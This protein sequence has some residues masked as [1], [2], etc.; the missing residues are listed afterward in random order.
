MTFTER[1]LWALA[2]ALVVLLAT[3]SPGH[4]AGVVDLVSARGRLTLNA[5]GAPLREVLAEVARATGAAIVG[6]D[7]AGDEQVSLAFSDL[8]L[9]EAVSRIL[10]E[11]SYLLTLG[12]KDG[13]DRL[14]RV[15]L[16]GTV[17]S[18]IGA[19]P[20]PPHD[21]AA[22]QGP[23]D[24]P[25]AEF[26]LLE[27]TGLVAEHADEAE[28]RSLLEEM[29]AG[30]SDPGVRRAALHGLLARGLLDG[31]VVLRT[32]HEDADPGLRE[33]ASHMLQLFQAETSG[34]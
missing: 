15:T 14:V 30:E 29:L 31:S 27:A 22:D 28:A 2:S 8:P 5:R 26:G 21:F 10:R 4:T 6:L 34:S 18:D 7:A 12:R 19:A 25:D 13:R 9:I 16:M 24:E 1:P 11:R 20:P 23:L 17:R 32:A 3:T 33:E